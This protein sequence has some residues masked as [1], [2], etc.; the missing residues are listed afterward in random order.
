MINIYWIEEFIN[1][2]F[3]DIIMT[4]A[5]IPFLILAHYSMKHK[6]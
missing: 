4:I 6:N 1:N 3:A 2:H 5:G